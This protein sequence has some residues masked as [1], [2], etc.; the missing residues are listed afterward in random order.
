[1]TAMYFIGIVV[2]VL[3]FAYLMYALANAEK[4]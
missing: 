4:F 1:M 3:L 2:T